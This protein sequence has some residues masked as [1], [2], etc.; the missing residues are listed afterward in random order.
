MGYYSNYL[1][2]HGILGQRWRKRNGPPYPLGKGDH[3]ASEKHAASKA[4]IKVGKDSGKGSIENVKGA[5]GSNQ[6]VKKAPLTEEEKRLKAEEAHLKGDSKNITKYMDKMTTQE[7]QDAQ[8]RAQIR[9]N[10]EGPQEKKMTKSEREIDEAIKSGDKEKV[11]EF[12]TKMTTQQLQD[13]MNKINLMQ[14]LNYKPPEPTTIEKIDNAM[15]KVNAV[16]NW[17]NTGLEAYDAL[18]KINN[19]FNKDSKWPRVNHDLKNEKKQE[20]AQS[21]LEKAIKTVTQTKAENDSRQIEKEKVKN[22]SRA[23]DLDEKSFEAAKKANKEQVKAYEKAQKQEAKNA[24][25]EAK[26]EKKAQKQAE[27]I[28]KV[29]EDSFDDEKDDNKSYEDEYNRMTRMNEKQVDK[30]LTKNEDA[31]FRA[32]SNPD[33]FDEYGNFNW[34]A[35]YKERN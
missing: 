30:E 23:L 24:K 9:K 18:A 13:A 16:K 21:K 33:N 17:M 35:Y 5:A 31:M 14:A 8:T 22:Q 19:T 28:A 27:R 2:H 32:I 4:G 10:L 12:A 25:A 20:E 3:S 29:V 26:A 7:L 11:K 6:H 34:D 1:A 15:K